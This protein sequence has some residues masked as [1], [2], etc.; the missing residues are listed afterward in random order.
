MFSCGACADGGSPSLVWLGVFLLSVLCQVHDLLYAV[1]TP[2]SVPVAEACHLSPKPTYIL[3]SNSSPCCIWEL[4][5]QRIH[6]SIISQ[7]CKPMLLLQSLGQCMVL[8]SKTKQLPLSSRH[9]FYSIYHQA[10]L[11]M[12][13]MLLN[14]HDSH[15]ISP[16]HS[17]HCSS[18]YY[19]FLL[20]FSLASSST[21]PHSFSP[22]LILP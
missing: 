6:Q 20:H 22:S 2:E 21:S 3:S 1:E 11:L 19:I 17:H 13:L 5:T 18:R 14:I 12:F 16:F 9:H 15:C 10:L 8:L 4:Q 7:Q